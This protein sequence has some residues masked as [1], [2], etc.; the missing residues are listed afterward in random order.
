[1]K[2]K[3][4]IQYLQQI[5][6]ETQLF[7]HSSDEIHLTGMVPTAAYIK[8]CNCSISSH[9]KEKKIISRYISLVPK[10]KE[11]PKEG[12]TLAIIF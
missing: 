2:A 4:L 5:D 11:E 8:S 3:E 1:M 6:P 10:Y 12:E 9:T 7:Q